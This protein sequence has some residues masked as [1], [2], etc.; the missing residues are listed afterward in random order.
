MQEGAS[1][2]DIRVLAKYRFQASYDDEKLGVGAGL[3]VPLESGNGI[4]TTER[5]LSPEDAVSF[6]C[7]IFKIGRPIVIFKLFAI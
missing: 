5:V 4:S 2:A 3:M 1:E 6:L 7:V